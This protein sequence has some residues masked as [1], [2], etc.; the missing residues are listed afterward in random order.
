MQFSKVMDLIDDHIYEDI[1][2]LI[3][4]IYKLDDNFESVF[5]DDK[6]LIEYQSV[7]DTLADELLTNRAKI[8]KLDNL[9][10][11]VR[12]PKKNILTDPLLTKISKE[13]YA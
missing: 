12:N 13:L 11:W 9:N 2:P 10:I 3:N 7:S 5:G 8:V 4:Y 6:D 1:T